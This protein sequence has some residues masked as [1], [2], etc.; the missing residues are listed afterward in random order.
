V[1]TETLLSLALLFT[2]SLVLAACS[3][4]SSPSQSHGARLVY[5]DPP[6][7]GS[8]RLVR[9]PNSTDARLLLDLVVGDQA[10]RGFGVAINLPAPA[11]SVQLPASGL[12][13]NTALLDPGNAPKT[14]VAQQLTQGPAA[15]LL[16]LGVARKRAARTDGDVALPA[17][18]T[19]LTVE[20]GL[21]AQAAAGTVFDAGDPRIHATLIAQ[22]GSPVART[23]QF[24]IGSLAVAQ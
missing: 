17:K 21:A 10:L 14:A 24:A 13:V 20:L 18:A 8:L 23:T 22:D 1:K 6:A 4:S 11:S 3:S 16:T 19:L 15:G 2:L 12:T 5:T 9:N 7:G